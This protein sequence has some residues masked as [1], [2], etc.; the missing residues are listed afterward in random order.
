MADTEFAVEGSSGEEF[1]VQISDE[2]GGEDV[3]AAG[4]EVSA[5]VDENGFIRTIEKGSYTY[6]VSYDEN[7]EVDSIKL[8]STS[9][10]RRTQEVDSANRRRLQDC[11]QSCAADANRLCGALTFGCGDAGSSLASLLGPLCDGLDDLC[12]EAGI[13]RGCTRTCAPGECMQ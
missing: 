7:D 2:S 13:L 10:S 6:E 12:N 1:T 3:I 11:E 8:V 5:S 9:G 4:D